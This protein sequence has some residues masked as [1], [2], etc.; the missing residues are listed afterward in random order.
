MF[1]KPFMA[2]LEGHSDTVNAIARKPDSLA[3]IASAGADGEIIL[4]DLPQR[5]HLM[6][7]PHAHERSITGICFA[8]PD[9]LLSCGADQLV[10]LWDLKVTTDGDDALVL[11]EE[12]GE[13]INI[14]QK[15]PLSL[16]HGKAAFNAIDHHRASPLFATGSNVVQVW[17]ENKTSAISNITFASSNETVISLKFN[18]T[19]QSVLATTGT[20]RTFTLYDIRT[21]KAERR[22][23]FELRANALSWSPMMPTVVLLASEDHT[24]STFDIRKL[25]TATQVY[26]GHVAPVM[27]CDWS[28]TGTE[29]VSGGWD[30]TVRVW[31][32]G[33]GSGSEPYFTKRMQRVF[34]TIFSGD[35][36]YVLSG[37]DEG[38]IR[39]WKAHPSEKL[40]ILTGKEQST[41]D[42]RTQLR[43][44]WKY[45]PDVSRI[46]R[47]R[48]LPRAIHQTRKL[49]TTMTRARQ[50]KEDNRRIHSRLGET[51]PKPEKSKVIIAEQS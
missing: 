37:S 7:L 23:V 47:K 4:H 11:D 39:L 33:K 50:T 15:K 27:S 17:D 9:R 12:T 1:A 29:F 43:E 2:S 13:G 21:G 38:N 25:S 35:A 28:P 48:F 10:K 44:K 36:R 30:R 31:T 18:L 41:R 5:R 32:E 45:D 49:H 3:A 16:Y 34:S 42:Y 19:E 46:E 40:G 26:K 6:R 24:L 22:L 14:A 51:K 20:D 8:G